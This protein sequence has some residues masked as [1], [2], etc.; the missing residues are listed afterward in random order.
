MTGAARSPET[1]SAGSPSAAAGTTGATVMSGLAWWAPSTLIPQGYTLVVSIVAARFLGPDAFGVQTFIA[2][3]EV[4]LIIGLSTGFSLAL[5]RFFAQALGSGQRDVLRD[6]VRWGWRVEGTAAILGGGVLVVAALV[7]ASPRAAWVFAGVA[8]TVG[9]MHSI[10]SAVLIGAQRWRDASIVGLV[11]GFFSTAAVVAVLWAGGGVVGMFAVEA[12]VSF[13]NLLWTGALARRAMIG[14][15]SGDVPAP[16]LRREASR[17]ALISTVTSLVAFVVWRRS[18]LFFLQAYSSSSV[19]GFYSIAFAA[20]SALVAIPQAVGSVFS[21][22][23]ATL[24][25][26]HAFERLRTG[27]SRG[28]RLLLAAALP[29]TAGAL[30]LGPALLTSVYGSDYQPTG[31]VFLILMAPFPLIAVTFFARA[32]LAGI[33]NVYFP[34]L[35]TSVAAAVNVGLDF[36]LIPRYDAGGAA[37]ANSVAQVGAGIAFL[38]YVARSLRPLRWEAAAL[39]GPPSRPQQ[40]AARRGRRDRRSRERPAWSPDSPW[41]QRSSSRSAP[42]L[43]S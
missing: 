13:L 2:F 36:L 39:Q 17:Y 11:T 21:P 22:A 29:V 43:G 31:D 25:G 41:A 5:M 42:C 35:V 37:V 8:T 38:V 3:T 30:A 14:C 40:A 33:G 1:D 18:E 32:Y 15:S 20:L 27:Y 28:M 19:V 24:F 12:A 9:V 23:A 10:P 34:L 26:A 6:L 7:G 4:S 16:K